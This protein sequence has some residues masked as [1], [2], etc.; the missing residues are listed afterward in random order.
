MKKLFLTLGILLGCVFAYA[1]PVSLEEASSLGQKFVNANFAQDRQ[2][3][4]LTLVYS[5]PSF[6]IFN[7]GNNGFVILSADDS[8]RPVIAYSNEGVF[9]AELKRLG[10][11]D[12]VYMKGSRGMHLDELA[13]AL[14][15]R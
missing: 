10:A 5:T 9:E 1:N 7:V 6:Y 11:G 14:R 8:Y 13:N 12:V 3:S 2:S 15:D 4:E